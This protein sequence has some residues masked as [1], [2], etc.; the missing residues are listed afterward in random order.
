[1]ITVEKI[2]L[3]FDPEQKNLLPALKKISAAFGYVSQKD[4][5]K[6]A[7][8]FSLPLS[9]IYETASFYD[10]IQVE[11]PPELLIQ[12]CSST[13]CAVNRSFEIVKEIENYFHVKAGDDNNPKVKLEVV[14]CLGMCGDGPIVVVNGKIHTGVTN[15]SIA[16]ILKGWA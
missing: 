5:G 14:S 10:M 12:V 4:G 11:N 3:E 6:I 8:Y 13:H 16:G 7:E 9:K 1:M 2:L 15:S